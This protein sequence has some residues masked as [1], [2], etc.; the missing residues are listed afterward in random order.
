[1]FYG[2]EDSCFAKLVRACAGVSF[3]W[4]YKCATGLVLMSARGSNGASGFD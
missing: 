3:G 4:K 1:M 2:F